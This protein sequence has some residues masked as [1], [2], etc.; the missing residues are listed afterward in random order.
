MASATIV[1]LGLGIRKN[2]RLIPL[3]R[4][5]GGDVLVQGRWRD[6]FDPVDRN[7]GELLAPFHRRIV[8]LDY[9]LFAPDFCPMTGC[10]QDSNQHI[11]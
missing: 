6:F 1:A 7:D 3:N 8:G 2:S 5:S 10:G 9:C 11:Q 4:R